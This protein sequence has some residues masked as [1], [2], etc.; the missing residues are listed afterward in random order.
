MLK[1]IRNVAQVVQLNDVRKVFFFKN[2]VNLLS[3]FQAFQCVE[4]KTMLSVV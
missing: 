3:S 4:I 1:S 2:D